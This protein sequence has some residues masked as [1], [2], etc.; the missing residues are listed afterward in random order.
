MLA[1]TLN[2]G[3]T[4]VMVTHSQEYARHAHRVV[5]MLDGHLV[6]PTAD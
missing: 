1:G 3:T 4:I 2:G 5:Q 6:D